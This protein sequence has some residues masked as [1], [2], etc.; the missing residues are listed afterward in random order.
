[1][2]ENLHLELYDCLKDYIVQFK[3]TYIE[4][5][6]RK[7][8]NLKREVGGLEVLRAIMECEDH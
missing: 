6:N 2:E 8:P 3:K 7:F 5:I 1:M 4:N